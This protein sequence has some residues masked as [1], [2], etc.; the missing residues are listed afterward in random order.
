MKHTESLHTPELH[1][2]PQV[3]ALIVLGRNFLSGIDRKVLA[4]QR[5]TLSA[6]SRINA[7]ATGLLYKA[8]IAETMILSSGQTAGSNLPSEAYAMKQHILRIFQGIPSEAIQL[9]ETSI[10]TE[11]NAREVKKIVARQHP[12]HASFGLLTD[13]SHLRRAIPMFKRNGLH[14]HPFDSLRILSK[15]RPQL[16]EKYVASEVYQNTIQQDALIGKML[17]VPLLYPFSSWMLRIAVRTMRNP[18]RPNPYV[19]QKQEE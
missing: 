18:N 5:F 19:V 15:S 9:E 4:H 16:I 2:L 11:G 12:E 17:S 8:G 14:V 10:D 7:L 13:T 1:H 6:Q 3:H